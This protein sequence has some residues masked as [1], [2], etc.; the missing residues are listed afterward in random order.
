MLCGMPEGHWPKLE[1]AMSAIKPVP[2]LL[3]P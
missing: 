3:T 1:L 2:L